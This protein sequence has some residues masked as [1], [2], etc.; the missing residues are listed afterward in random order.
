MQDRIKM[1]ETVTNVMNIAMGKVVAKMYSRYK[2]KL[3]P[4]PKYIPE[5]DVGRYWLKCIN[6]AMWDD[7]RDIRVMKEIMRHIDEVWIS[8]PYIPY[9]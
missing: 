7:K 8:I 9:K 2:G 5:N 3:K 6:W 1:I 4:V